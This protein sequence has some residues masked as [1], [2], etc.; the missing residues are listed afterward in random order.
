MR[1]QNSARKYAASSRD[2]LAPLAQ[3]GH[4]DRHDA[5]AIEEILAE[6]A[7]GDQLVETAVG[8]RDDADRD[9]NRLLAA[10]ALQLAVLQ[11][12]Q[13]LGLR[14]L[15]QVADFVEKD[16]CRRRPA[17]TC[18]AAA[19]A[20]P[21]NAPFS[22]PNSSLSI[23][24]VGMAAQLTFTNG[25]RRERALAMDVR[26]QQLLAGARLAGQQHAGVGSRD[27]RR[28]LHRAPERRARA[29]HPRRVA[30]QLAE[31]LVL[32]LQVRPLERVLHDEQHAVAGERLLEEVE[33]AAARRL[34]RVADRAVPG[35]H[36]HRRRVV[37]LPAA[38]A[39]GRCRCRRAAG[40]RA[41]TDRRGPCARSAWN[42]AA[43]S[44]TVT[45]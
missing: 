12:A 25:P 28:L 31:A 20:A 40:R 27:L 19:P 7:V 33:R 5:Q 29:D 23:S 44:Q 37:A 34:D 43:E 3:R 17:R 42:R 45:R 14:R 39:A 22:W 24:S 18:R 8:R 15:V 1:A 6:L 26:R 36:H 2:V 13:Q 9:A 30:D 4:A 11:D 32:A 21:V 35:D 10:D 38:R 41:G 16:A